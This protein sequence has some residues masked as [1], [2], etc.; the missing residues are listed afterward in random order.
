MRSTLYLLSVWTALLKFVIIPIIKNKNK[1]IS[2]KDNYRPICLAN[3]FTKEW[4][5]KFCLTVWMG[6]YNLRLM[7]LGSSEQKCVFLF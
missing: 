6:I 3:V 4:L 1:R 7:N 5:K 2:D